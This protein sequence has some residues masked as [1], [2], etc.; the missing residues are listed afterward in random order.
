MNDLLAGPCRYSL[1]ELILCCPKNY[2]NHI[3]GNCPNL[4]IFINEIDSAFSKN[5]I[6]PDDDFLDLKRIKSDEDEVLNF[7]L[8][9]F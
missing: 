9:L 6:P 7:S 8:R 1:Q 4:T 2:A 5:L 3:E